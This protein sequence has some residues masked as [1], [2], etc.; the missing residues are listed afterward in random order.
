MK[1]A[2]KKIHSCE[3]QFSGSYHMFNSR[4]QVAK[5]FGNLVGLNKSRKISGR[6][7]KVFPMVVQG[8]LDNAFYS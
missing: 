5:T 8:Y 3:K 4:K 2:K 1:I 7:P 6:C